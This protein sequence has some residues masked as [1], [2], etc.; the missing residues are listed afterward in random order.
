VY[1]EMQTLIPEKAGVA[2][3]R[4]ITLTGERRDP[5]MQ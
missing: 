4:K 1:E 3:I 5:W 2:I